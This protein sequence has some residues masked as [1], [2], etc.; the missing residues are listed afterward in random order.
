[1]TYL[2]E[3]K[4][5][6]PPMQK[7]I[8]EFG[9]YNNAPV[10]DDGQMRN[11]FNLSSDKYP[12]LY[13]RAKR[14]LYT[15]D[16]SLQEYDDPK[17][18]LSRR[19]K[20]A[21]VSGTD[22]YYGTQLLNGHPV[23]RRVPGITLTPGEK[24]L[25]AI[26][27]RIVIYP[28][29]IW[30][31][32]ETGQSGSLDA[33]F[34]VPNGTTTTITDDKNVSKIVLP[35]LPLTSLNGFSA[36]DA[37][38][39][40]GFSGG[41]IVTSV[42]KSVTSDGL[43]FASDAFLSII[44]TATS[45]V[46][47]ERLTIS[48]Q[49]PNLDFVMESNNRLWGCEGNTIWACKLGD[50]LNWNYYQALSND[51]YA[52]EVGT[53][54]AWTGCCAYSNHLLFFKEDC[55]HKIYGTKPSNYQ[56]QT[57]NCY[58]L[59]AGSHKSISVIN[60]TVF[61]KS[62]LG[63]MAYAGGIPEHITENF[64]TKKYKNAVSGTDGIKYFVSMESGGAWDFFVFDLG[65]KMW[66]KEDHTKAVDFAYVKGQLVYINGEDGQIY[67]LAPE[68]TLEAEKDIHW[69]AELGDFD[70]FQ[71]EKKVYSR[72]KLRVNMEPDSEITVS[73]MY[74]GKEWIQVAQ[75]QTKHERTSF[76]PIVPVRCDK[77]RIKL[78]GIGYS[79]VE[80]IVR[81]YRERSIR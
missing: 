16:G 56:M 69:M 23:P 44:G 8:I 11:M 13:Q 63:I 15:I 75:L 76:I 1:M 19:E 14:G 9:G 32:V 54:G 7:Q 31:N 17:E 12:N 29:K 51:S 6:V 5:M 53:D 35:G 58:A 30:Y 49:S 4:M 21:V 40:S 79:L 61:Y 26:N 77:F 41:R 27:T 38:E 43:T 70:E 45:M 60:E 28:D 22:F 3:I 24:Q 71:E 52:V 66:H 80:S 37:V 74:D 59:E 48:R 68:R 25:V 78:E 65:K 33:S 55:I 72:I 36:G 50:P 64:G 39:I 18:L 34:K 47:A 81:E 57:T 10:I 46:I 73:V 62:R 42:I 2:P 20:L 67:S